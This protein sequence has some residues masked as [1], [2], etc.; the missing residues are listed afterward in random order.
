MSGDPVV[1]GIVSHQLAFV[2]LID[3]D[4]CLLTAFGDLTAAVHSASVLDEVGIGDPDSALVGVG[5]SAAAAVGVLHDR[6]M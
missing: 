3:F 4:D 2:A 6:S 1:S 5:H